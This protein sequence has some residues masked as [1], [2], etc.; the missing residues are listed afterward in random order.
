MQAEKII[1]T[2]H[3]VKIFGQPRLLLERAERGG[4]GNSFGST[5]TTYH[6]DS[7][8]LLQGQADVPVV[9]LNPLHTLQRIV[10]KPEIPDGALYIGD[11]EYLF[12]KNDGASAVGG[13][14]YQNEVY[15]DRC[16]S[17]PKENGKFAV[18]VASDKVLASGRT[19][20]PVY[21]LLLN[22]HSAF[23]MLACELLGFFPVASRRRPHGGKPERLGR[24]QSE[25]YLQIDNDSTALT[26]K[27]FEEANRQGGVDFIL[28]DG[29]TRKFNIFVLSLSEDIEGKV[30]KA[31]VPK[32][33]CFRCFNGN[34]HFGSSE[35]FHVCGEGPLGFRNPFKTFDL[36]VVLLQNQSVKM[37]PSE[38]DKRATS[39]GMKH[40][41]VVNQL[42]AFTHCFGDEGVYGAM[43]YDD[44]HMLFLGLFVLILSAADILFCR[45]FKRT[46]LVQT[47]ED[48]H[49]L[50]EFLLSMSPG[51][52]VG[53]HVLKAMRM[54]WF[55]LES[56]N[57]VDNE[58]FFSH[59]LFI[60][61]THDALI[62]DGCTRMAFATIVRTLYS[63]YVRFKVKKFYRAAELEQLSVDISSVLRDLKTLFALT[64]D[65]KPDARTE[66]GMFRFSDS[67]P[68]RAMS[69]FHRDEAVATARAS[70]AAEA[71]GK[72]KIES[73]GKR[74]RIED[75]NEDSVV[76]PRPPLRKD[77]DDEDSDDHTASESEEEPDGHF[78]VNVSVNELAAVATLGG[79]QTRTHKCHA[80]TMIPKQIKRVGS[81]HVGSSS[82][83]E[84]KHRL[85]KAYTKRSNLAQL[86]AVEGQVIRNSVTSRFVQKPL[87]SVKA[88]L[89]YEEHASRETSLLPEPEES[90]EED[91]L[92]I[93]FT[94]DGTGETNY[95]FTQNKKKK[96]LQKC[97]K[98]K[99]KN[100]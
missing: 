34:K 35:P 1:K 5:P 16:A 46:K 83:Y 29:T 92:P 20:Y 39:L 67:V 2:E 76:P 11:G 50:V 4:D 71:A 80:F 14:V 43:N 89:Y 98:K 44:L 10:L 60:F 37:L 87:S 38:T 48:V 82:L 55:R 13:Q 95:F 68:V 81:L 65:D 99:K 59:L 96:L 100:Y 56:W 22:V 61:S 79:H 97:N 70:E 64:V 18:A 93:Q 94:H 72:K 90:D 30:P 52:N 54:G 47:Y 69:K 40:F 7:A 26:L 32:N 42:L 58:C 9:L 3:D 51:M 41:K 86:G 62:E 24:G 88:R 49:Q 77:G 84:R 74:H 27:L 15:R 75:E 53:V 28:K 33:W 36:L 85:V 6:L 78:T 63:L 73:K 12:F 31:V 45:H 17:F 25:A 21:L 66:D 57:G 19:S 23:A 8:G 91:S